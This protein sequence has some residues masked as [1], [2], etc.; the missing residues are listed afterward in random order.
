MPESLMPNDIIG[1]IKR[2]A[3]DNKI[4]ALIEMFACLSERWWTGE[5]PSSLTHSLHVKMD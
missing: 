3:L 1:P 4:T 2:C 5:E